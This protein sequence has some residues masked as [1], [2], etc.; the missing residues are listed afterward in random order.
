MNEAMPGPD[1]ADDRV[2]AL[3]KAIAAHALGVRSK[4]LL[5]YHV[6]VQHAIECGKAL[7]ELKQ[8]LGYGRWGAWVKER[9]GLNRMT[10]NRYMRLSGRTEKLTRYMTIREAYLAAQVITEKGAG[11]GAVR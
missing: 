8:L 5:R 10:A 7:A 11:P 6:R 4:G 9:C 1:S 3:T 2:L